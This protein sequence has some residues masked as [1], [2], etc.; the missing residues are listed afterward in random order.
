[1]GG[2][3]KKT[4]KKM[5]I[6]EGGTPVKKLAHVFFFTVACVVCHDSRGREQCSASTVSEWRGSEN[7]SPF[8]SFLSSSSFFF[9]VNAF[10][11]GTP[12]WGDKLLGV[13][14]VGEQGYRWG[15]HP[16]FFSPPGLRHSHE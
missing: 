10:S 13:V 16:S 14:S 7:S 15:V 9:L 11:V 2:V 8:F 4:R 6:L 5:D 3:S 1:M 12:F